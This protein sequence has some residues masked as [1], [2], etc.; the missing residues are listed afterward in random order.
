VSAT[1]GSPVYVLSIH[2]HA[3]NHTLSFDVKDILDALGER[4]MRWQWCVFY[5]LEAYGLGEKLASILDT[6][7]SIRSGGI[8]LSA[9]EFVQLAREIHQTVDGEFQAFLSEISALDIPVEEL[10]APFP[11]SRGQLSIRAV[12]STW[13]EVYA[14]HR[15]DVERIQAHFSEVRIEDPSQYF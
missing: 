4:A 12:D 8:W 2:V 9:S 1:P 11:K 14:K 10:D 7:E 6:T 5:D 15:E 13:F 3:P